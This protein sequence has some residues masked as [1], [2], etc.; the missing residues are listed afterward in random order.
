MLQL[1]VEPTNPYDDFAVSMVKEGVVVGHVPLYVSGVVCFFLN[2]AGSIGFCEV[3]ASQ[4]NRR[5][6]L[7]LEVP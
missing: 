6:G 1:K 3:T 7:R 2:R 4:V 5:V